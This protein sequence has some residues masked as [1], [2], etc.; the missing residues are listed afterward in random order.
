M[1]TDD[2]QKLRQLLGMTAAVIS[3]MDAAL[4]GRTET[5]RTAWFSYKAFA[6]RYMAIINQLPPGLSL[7]GDLGPIR[8]GQYAGTIRLTSLV[9]ETNLRGRLHKPVNPTVY[10]R[11]H[12]RDC[13]RRETSPY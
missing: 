2:N 7:A 3:S 6:T 10:P 5:D 1:T 12:H 9:P 13:R 11:K 8:H 4:R